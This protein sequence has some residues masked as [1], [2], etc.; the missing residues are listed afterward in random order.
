MTGT[1]D[2]GTANRLSRRALLTGVAGLV[3]AAAT[4]CAGSDRPRAAA[5]GRP[6]AGPT[7][8]VPASPSAG[9]AADPAAVKANELGVIPVMMY[10]RITP[11]V[12]GEFDMTPKD[13]RAQLQRLFHEGY[14]PVRT[15]DLAR[16]ELTVAAGY[17]PVVLTFDDGYTD[18]FRMSGGDVDPECAV[19]IILDVAKQ[20][21]DCAPAGS[22]NINNDPF[23]LATPAARATGLRTLHELGFEIA[24]HTF[25][26]DNLRQLDGPGVQR[27][28]VQLQR[29]VREAV[30]EASVLTMA[31]PFGVAP[32]DRALASR[33]SWE[34]DSYTNEAVLLVGANPSRSPFSPSFAPAAIPRIRGTSW[35]GGTEEFTGTYW[36]DYLSRHRS[37]RY[38]SAGHP[39]HVTVP[40]ALAAQ[41]APRY[42]DRLVTY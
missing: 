23:G 40:K 19:G 9:P 37:R 36:L 4:A 16:G 21:P 3:G 15:I 24:N 1:G 32:A 13:F 2:N 31:L 17:T 26:H 41:V 29:L 39:G 20:F 42:R 22:F 27:D 7:T 14:R 5:T 10:H 8:G 6:P 33:G 18:Q 11:A 38:V 35:R 28:F 25:G 34:G 30:P 12:A